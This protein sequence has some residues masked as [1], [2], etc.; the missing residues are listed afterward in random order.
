MSPNNR[1]QALIL[2]GSDVLPNRFG[3]AP[4]MLLE[5]ESRFYMLLPGPPK[6]LEPMFENE[7][8]PLILE[9][10]GSREKIVSRVLR[11]FGIGES[12]L[13]TDLEDL[14]DAQTNPTIAPLA[15]DGEVTLRL[16]AKHAD[17]EETNRL[18]K[19]TEDRIL[20]RVGE[21]FYGYD[22]TSLAEE[23]CESMPEQGYDSGCCGK[24]YRRAFFQL[25]DGN[26]R[27]FRI[28][29]RRR[30][31]L[32]KRIESVSGRR[33]GR[34]AAALWCGQRAMR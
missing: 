12:Q 13:E 15:A 6:E 23:A 28:F 29:Q 33:F 21:F 1:K 32:H 25:A 34:H 11:F 7:A 10:L 14:I 16:T 31:L 2:E 22:D 20:E 9:K 3:M 26:E 18:L 17:P 4:G 5:H 30:R 8:K 24:L 27:R 19:E